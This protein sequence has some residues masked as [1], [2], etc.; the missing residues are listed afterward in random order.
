MDRFQSKLFLFRIFFVC[1]KILTKIIQLL[2]Y[3]C[4]MQG[5]SSIFGPN[6]RGFKSRAG[7]NGA[8]TVHKLIMRQIMFNHSKTHPYDTLHQKKD[9]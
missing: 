8:C 3:L 6:I 1:Y 4:T 9:L 7:Y 2:Q 5:N